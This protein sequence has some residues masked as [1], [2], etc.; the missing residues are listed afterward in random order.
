MK[1]ILTGVL[2]LVLALGFTIFTQPSAVAA[3]SPDTVTAHL[4]VSVQDDAGNSSL[5][6][7]AM[8]VTW[9]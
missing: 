2:A 1:K 5:P 9:Q 6:K 7:R 4:T 3:D 8:E